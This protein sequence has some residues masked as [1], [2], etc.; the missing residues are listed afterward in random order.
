MRLQFNVIYFVV[1]VED[2]YQN[3]YNIE[4]KKELFSWLGQLSLFFFLTPPK[5]N[6]VVFNAFW[7]FWSFFSWPGVALPSMI[8][9]LYWIVVGKTTPTPNFILKT[10]IHQI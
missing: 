7:N 3:K 9:Y 1:N 10:I 2:L 4:K 5:R 8:V 6:R